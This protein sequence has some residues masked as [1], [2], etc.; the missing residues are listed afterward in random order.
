M[1]GLIDRERE[2]AKLD[3]LWQRPGPALGL[4]YG[5]RRI[6]KTYFLQQA[7]A[8]RRGLYFLAAESSSLE[9]LQELLAQVR[10]AFP[11]R[12]DATLESYPTWRVA[13]RLLCDLARGQPLLV[14]FD[15][16]SYLCHVEPS[17][18]SLLQAVWDQEA[19]A[20]QLKLILCGSEVGLL[21]ALDEYGRPLHGRFDWVEQYRP[22]DYYDA[23]RFLLAARRWQ[24]RDLLLAYGIYGGSGRYLSAVAGEADLGRSVQSLLLDPLGPFHN[25][26][27]N[28]IRYERDIRDY[29][30]YNSVLAAIAAGASEW[31]EIANQAHLEKHVVAG[32]LERLQQLGWVTHERPFGEP[33]RRGLYRLNDNL[34]KFWYRFIFRFRSAL[35]MSL[36]QQAWDE[37]VR[38]HLDTYMG[39][40]VFEGVCQEHLSRFQRRYHLPVITALGRWWN[41]RSDTELDLVASLADGSYLLGECKWSH[42]PLDVDVLTGLQRKA[43]AI[44]R[45]WQREPLRYALFSSGGFKP[46]LEEYAREQGCLLVGPGLL[47]QGLL[48]WRAKEK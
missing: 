5:R 14:V 19:P 40:Y 47:Y 22:L 26:G 43:E 12:T 46:R 39:M 38:P 4:L 18:P 16:F 6:G 13:L 41:R 21:A 10:S 27:D 25:E 31:G 9:N 34:L 30:N 32:C 17:L 1:I 20:T 35:Q 37:L 8:G 3:E 24:P 15:E 29:A 7:M 42:T 45:H 2:R 11:G 44:P 28:L 33:G 23:A 36:P 48:A